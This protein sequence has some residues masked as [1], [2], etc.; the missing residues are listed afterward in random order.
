[1]TPSIATWKKKK[2]GDQVRAIAAE[3]LVPPTSF[4]TSPSRFPPPHVQDGRLDALGGKVEEVYRSCVEDK[5]DDL[6]TLQMLVNME[7]HLS[8]LLESMESIPA[9]TREKVEK[10]KRRER[11]V[12]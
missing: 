8:T 3:V 6:S 7:S 4:L 9:D 2:T 1:M 12:R 5:K 11:R 10:M